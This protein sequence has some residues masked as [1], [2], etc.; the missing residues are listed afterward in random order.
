MRDYAVIAKEVDLY[1]PKFCFIVYLGYRLVLKRWIQ[2]SQ[3]GPQQL[4][5]TRGHRKMENLVGLS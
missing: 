4:I 5:I 3:N 2:L 1:L